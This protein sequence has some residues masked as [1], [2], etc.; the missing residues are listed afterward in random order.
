MAIPLSSPGGSHANNWK[1]I[2]S[3]SPSAVP[4]QMVTMVSNSRLHGSRRAAL[5]DRD[6]CAG[7]LMTGVIAMDYFQ[8]KFHTDQ[9]GTEVAIIFSL[10]TVSVTSPGP[11]PDTVSP[12]DSRFHQRSHGWRTIRSHP[13]RQVRPSASHVR[14][15]HCDHRWRGHHRFVIDHRPIRR[16]PVR[17]WRWHLHHDRCGTSVF[18]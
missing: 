5:T 12:I 15:R 9:T 7:S 8:A 6:I 1:Q 18:H 4:V 16:R 13:L 14:R 10:Y 3:S 2:P 11:A 17:P